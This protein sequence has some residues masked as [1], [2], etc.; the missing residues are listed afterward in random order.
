[1]RL[2]RTQLIILASAAFLILVFAL[3]FTGVLPGLRSRQ[4]EQ[5]LQGSLVVW[6]V[7]DSES[8]FSS[9]I[10]RY[11]SLHPNVSISYI[12]KNEETFEQD[13]VNA[14][15]AGTGP[16]IFMFKNTWLPKHFDKIIP[17]SANQF[18]ITQ[19]R[20]IFPVVVEQDFTA[21]GQVFALP[22]HIDTLVM[23]SNSDI[24]D[25]SAI[26]QPPKTWQ[27]FINI[28]PK[29][30][31]LDPTNKIIRAGAAI[32]GSGLSI[33]RS[34]DILLALM[35]QDG[36][37]M[38]DDNFT[39]ATFAQSGT[40]ALRLYTNFANAASPAYTWNDQLAKSFDAFAREQAAIVFA[41]GSDL[42]KI[43]E[44]GP[45]LNI[46]V[47]E[48]PQASIENPLNY[49]SY[50]GLAVSKKTQLSSI[51]WNFI[52]FASTNEQ[53]NEA[54]LLS[55]FKSPAL[56]S[57]I[58]KFISH[59]DFSVFARQA[60]TARSWRQI[61]DAF[62]SGSFSKMIQSILGGKT[63]IDS[64]LK[65]SQDEISDLMRRKNEE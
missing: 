11:T 45:F 37:K 22:L 13:L 42:E 8:V 46:R 15:A 14:L 33:E 17:L 60:L 65:T 38:T 30:R 58:D 7:R 39:S 10:D 23:V 12:Q 57:L 27:E 19:F 25:A 62:I 3:I 34:S 52:I 35:L 28:V 63:S 43:R 54:Y 26:A 56:R 51:A 5:T 50:W 32:G 4:A 48:F 1:M 40:R 16:D 55:A 18:P 9:L 36:V 24:L 2:T 47:S 31:Q 53:A 49:A 29:L 64:A 61:D 21:N 44:K 20:Q 41:Y 6:G 59:P